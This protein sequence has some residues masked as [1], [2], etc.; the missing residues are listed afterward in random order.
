MADDLPSGRNLTTDPARRS[1]PRTTTDRNPGFDDPDLLDTLE[2]MSIDQ[3]DRLDFGLI[4]ADDTNTVIGY[5]ANESARSGLDPKRT[6]GRNLFS[7]VAPCINNYLVAERYREEADLDEQ[8][9]YVFTFVMRPTPVRLR[10]M[11]RQGSD[12]RYLAVR[13]R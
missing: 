11:R 3:F 9:D 10:L 12:R 2:G 7:S 5:N 13:S 4:V 6:I 1:G 8:L